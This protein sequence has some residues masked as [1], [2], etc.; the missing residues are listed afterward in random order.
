MMVY[1]VD[2]TSVPDQPIE[3]GFVV[4]LQFH[5]F[6]ALLITIKMSILSFIMSWQSIWKINCHWVISGA[7]YTQILD[8]LHFIKRSA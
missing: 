2:I 4:S 7:L 5:M 8:N 1:Q 6:R 3:I